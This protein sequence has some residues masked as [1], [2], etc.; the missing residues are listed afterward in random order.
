ML[1]Y[2]ITFLSFKANDANSRLIAWSGFVF[3]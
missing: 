2:F 1:V 3:R